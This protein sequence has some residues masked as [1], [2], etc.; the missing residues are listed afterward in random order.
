MIKELDYY[1]EK[2]YPLYRYIPKKTFRQILQHGFQRYFEIAR[3]GGAIYIGDSRFTSLCG[4]LN[5]NPINILGTNKKYRNKKLHMQYLY[6]C[7]EYDGM[8]YFGITEEQKEKLFTKECEPITCYKIK[9]ECLQDTRLKY[10]Y[11]LYYPVDRGWKFTYSDIPK[12]D[13]EYFAYRDERNKI[14]EING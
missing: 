8:Y 3:K 9:E 11:I 4:Y 5:T 7:Q 2:L 12:K 13:T 10:F 1:V 6:T 14:I